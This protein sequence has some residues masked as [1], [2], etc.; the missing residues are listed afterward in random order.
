MIS[1][2]SITCSFIDMTT[3]PPFWYCIVCH[4]K[5]FLEFLKCILDISWKLVSCC[6]LCPDDKNNKL[7]YSALYL[8][9][10]YL[11]NWS[12]EVFHSP[13][14]ISIDTISICLFHCVIPTSVIF[15]QSAE[16]FARSV[17]ANDITASGI[18][19]FFIS[20]WQDVAWSS[21]VEKV[22]FV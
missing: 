22:W 4:I 18:R 8:I 14:T 2:V 9:R 21:L 10:S 7:V 13:V 19:K 3:S 6:C 5:N 17:M 12:N 11:V 15:S 16:T 20:V 1:G